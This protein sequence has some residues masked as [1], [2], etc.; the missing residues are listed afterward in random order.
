M[1]GKCSSGSLSSMRGFSHKLWLPRE[2]VAWFLKE[3]HSQSQSRWEEWALGLPR[4]PAGASLTC[5]SLS[6]LLGLLYPA[7]ASHPAGASP[8][9]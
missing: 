8:P 7:G 5:W 3:P 9:C 6:T 1:L 2:R 4:H